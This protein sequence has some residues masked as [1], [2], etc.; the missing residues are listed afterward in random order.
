MPTGTSYRSMACI[1]TRSTCCKLRSYD[2]KSSWTLGRPSGA[3][4]GSMPF[5]HCRGS[6]FMAVLARLAN[7]ADF[8]PQTLRAEAHCGCA[9]AGRSSAKP[10]PL[11]SLCDDTYRMSRGPGRVEKLVGEL[12]ATTHNRALHQGQPMRVEAGTTPAPRPGARSMVAPGYVKG[13]IKA[14]ACGGADTVVNLQWADGSRGEGQGP[15]GA[16]ELRSVSSGA[17]SHRC[18]KKIQSSAAR[19]Y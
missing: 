6:R 4:C 2:K 5:G 8:D 13:Q 10:H 9:R 18:A 15:L 17:S 19:R 7:S 3:T 14:L 11:L 16:E 1:Q 12:F